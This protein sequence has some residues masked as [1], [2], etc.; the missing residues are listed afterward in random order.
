MDSLIPIPK[1]TMSNRL[2]YSISY[3]ESSEAEVMNNCC[4]EPASKFPIVTC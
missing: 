2:I 4:M 3:T 1:V